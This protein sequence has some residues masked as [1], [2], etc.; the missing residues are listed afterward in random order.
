MARG[1]PFL[2]CLQ[3][4]QDA[5]QRVCQCSEVPQHRSQR[6]T[7][8][9]LVIPQLLHSVANLKCENRKMH[10]ENRNDDRHTCVQ[11]KFNKQTN[12]GKVEK[13]RSIR[14]ITFP[15]RLAPLQRGDQLEIVKGVNFFGD[16]WR[17]LLDLGKGSK[18]SPQGVARGAS[19]PPPPECMRGSGS[20]NRTEN[21]LIF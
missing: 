6:V 12:K 5:S 18:N 15:R 20:F 7:R 13:T 16:F 8:L 17:L 3:R 1:Q 21:Y 9:F 4:S 10:R 11:S 19:P 14:G 2:T